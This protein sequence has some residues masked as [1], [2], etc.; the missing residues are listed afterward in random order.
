MA[1]AARRFFSCRRAI[2]VFVDEP[3]EDETVGEPATLFG[4]EEGVGRA[5]GLSGVFAGEEE[6]AWEEEEEGEVEEGGREAD[7][8]AIG[9]LLSELE[10]SESS[11]VI[12][13]FDSFVLGEALI[14]LEEEEEELSDDFC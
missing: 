4:V 1:K 8:G 3:G 12:E 10:L 14:S 2:T 11:T 9:F 7:A 13:S 5:K 6:F